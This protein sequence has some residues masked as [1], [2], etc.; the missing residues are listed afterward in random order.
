VD[1]KDAIKVLK[2]TVLDRIG[3]S[4]KFICD[5]GK[6]I[7]DF[8]SE[9]NELK[10][11]FSSLDVSENDSHLCDVSIRLFVIG[12]L[13]FYAQILGHDN[14]SGSWCMWCLMSLNEW[15][16]E[17]AEVPPNHAEEWTINTLKSHKVLVSEGTLKKPTEICGVVEFPIWDFIEVSHYSFL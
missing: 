10:L 16:K 3:N 1:Y 5:G 6:F 9:S 11:S 7:I 14:M 15:S 17:I 2:D 8:S 13:E 12:D 4:L